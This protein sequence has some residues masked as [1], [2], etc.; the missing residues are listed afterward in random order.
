MK[1]LLNYNLYK[2]NIEQEEPDFS[3][4]D[5]LFEVLHSINDWDPPSTL[6]FDYLLMSILSFNDLIQYEN[7][8]Q[9]LV[10]DYILLISEL[11][12]LVNS[13]N[14]NS[15]ENKKALNYFFNLEEVY[16]TQPLVLYKSLANLY[17]KNLN[18]I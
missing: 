4:I 7:K 3:N 15:I 6:T 16:R 2:T 8:N 18:L 13:T 1:M 9:P 14:I 5:Y 10:D 12:T 11:F 17:I